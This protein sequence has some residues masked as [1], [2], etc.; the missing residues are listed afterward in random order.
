MRLQIWKLVV[1]VGKAWHVRGVTGMWE[2]QAMN[3]TPVVV[4]K[5]QG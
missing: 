4:S 5:L 2:W 3:P 1:K